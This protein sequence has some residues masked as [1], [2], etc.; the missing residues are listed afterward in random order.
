MPIKE[1]IHSQIISE[2][3]RE[4]CGTTY[5]VSS[6]LKVLDMWEHS[7]T[8]SYMLF[9]NTVKESRTEGDCTWYH[10]RLPIFPV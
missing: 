6:Q 5:K 2:H 9:D 7:V 10:T 1:R 3:E 8:K 4:I